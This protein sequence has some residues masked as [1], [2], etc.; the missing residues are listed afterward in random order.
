ML[1]SQVCFE[2]VLTWPELGRPPGVWTSNAD[3]A[4]LAADVGLLLVNRASMPLKIV[5]RRKAFS[6]C[7]AWLKASVRLE[8][9]L[10]VLPCKATY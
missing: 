3:V 10:E 7:T 9:L 2:I 5:V 1:S 4:V 8:M 6:A